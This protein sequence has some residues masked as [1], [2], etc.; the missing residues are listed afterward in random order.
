M[1]YIVTKEG[2]T[3]DDADPT[4]VECEPSR[5]AIGS[6]TATTTAVLCSELVWRRAVTPR[7]CSRRQFE[8]EDEC[9]EEREHGGREEEGHQGRPHG[10]TLQTIGTT[11][12]S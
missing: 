1:E 8:D 3:H 10:R 11:T 2:Q 7:V 6:V 4:L 12:T 9:E 5:E